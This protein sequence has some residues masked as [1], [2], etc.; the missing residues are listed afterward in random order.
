LA[1]Q[2]TGRP[3]PPAAIPHVCRAPALTAASAS[4]GGGRA[5]PSASP[6]QHAARRSAAR[7]AQAWYAPHVTS[8]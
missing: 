5:C 1:P 3:A 2:Q 6:P 8:M 7:S 4:P